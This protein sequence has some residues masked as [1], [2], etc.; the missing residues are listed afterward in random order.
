MDFSI[1]QNLLTVTLSNTFC[2]YS[3]I[4]W[5][6]DGRTVKLMPGGKEKS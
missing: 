2:Y 1:Q 4:D 3:V 6:V 5:E